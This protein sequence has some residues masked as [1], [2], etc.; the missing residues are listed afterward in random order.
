MGW[1]HQLDLIFINTPCLLFVCVLCNAVCY[2]TMYAQICIYI[3]KYRYVWY[4][5]LCAC[6]CSNYSNIRWQHSKRW[7]TRESGNLPDWQ[8]LH[9]TIH[10]GW[11]YSPRFMVILVIPG[12]V[13][14]QLWKNRQLTLGSNTTSVFSWKKTAAN[15][16]LE[17]ATRKAT[18][19]MHINSWQFNSGPAYP[20]VWLYFT[21]GDQAA[22]PRMPHL[23][24]NY[25]KYTP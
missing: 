8:C 15:M 9:W 4:F 20:P 24:R 14:Y 7:Q 19:Q 23:A 22:H 16:E 11:W 12:I 18:N 13:N 17:N 21:S 6:F 5:G 2:T 10:P 1:N 3:F 25:R